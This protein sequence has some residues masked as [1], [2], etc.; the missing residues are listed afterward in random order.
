LRK[1][2]KTR[3]CMYC[4]WPI[5]EANEVMNCPFGTGCKLCDVC[6][7]QVE[8]EAGAEA[9]R[10]QREFEWARRKSNAGLSV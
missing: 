9:V 1:T 5:N 2:P 7:R 6:H 4:Y 10:L 8:R 3:S